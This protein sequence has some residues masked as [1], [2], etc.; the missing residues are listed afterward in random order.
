MS[1]RAIIFIR[2][3]AMCVLPLESL[4][5]GQKEKSSALTRCLPLFGSDTCRPDPHYWFD[6][7][8][9]VCVCLCVDY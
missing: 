3:M 6:N 2:S 7:E 1:A 5:S 9:L 4:E 8:E